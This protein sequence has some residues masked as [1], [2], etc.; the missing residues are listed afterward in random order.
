MKPFVLSTIFILS[1]F[2]TA[3]KEKATNNTET[4]V[5]ETTGEASSMDGT[6]T[7]DPTSSEIK[8]QGSK[9]TGVHNGTVPV[10]AGTFTVQDGIITSGTI[11]IDMSGITV[12]DLEGESKGN[13]E[14]HLKGTVEGKEQDFFNTA[15]F[16]KA[17]YTVTSS[18]KLD[19]D[20]DGTHMINGN[21]TIKDITKPVSFKARVNADG[22]TF[23][24]TTPQFAVDRTEYDIQFKSKKFFDNLRDDFIDDEFKLQ[25]TVNARKA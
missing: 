18:S 25:I 20:P 5:T 6:Y 11:D 19:N 2:A 9:P 7:I 14:A 12:L 8:W 10:S 1:L 22:N 21:L 3:C 16:P 15:K 23:S 13:L 17:T 24:A 4:E